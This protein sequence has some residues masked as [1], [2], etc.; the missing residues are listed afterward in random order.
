MALPAPRHSPAPAN[1]AGL[2]GSWASWLGEPPEA[3]LAAEITDVQEQLSH[4]K[5]LVEETS[6]SSNPNPN[7]NPNPKP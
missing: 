1:D 2:L 3:K 4:V 7:P 6:L 5:S